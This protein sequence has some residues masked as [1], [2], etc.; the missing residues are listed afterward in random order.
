[1][2]LTDA[3]ERI[4][5]ELERLAEWER[6]LLGDLAA[7]RAR[8]SGLL[9]AIEALLAELPRPER[10]PLR[11]RLNRVAVELAGELRTSPHQTDKVEALHTYLAGA[12][13]IVTV[14][15][16]QAFLKKHGLAA[17]DDAAAILL[18]RKAKQ[19]IV[20]RV[21]RGRYKVNHSHPV[22]AAAVRA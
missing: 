10:T 4:T 7:T 21:A 5:T 19:G 14:K 11:L 13:G 18:A 17:Y 9:K 2:T 15:R 22:I 3:A 6:D 8:R 1:M 12:E 20:E 16:V